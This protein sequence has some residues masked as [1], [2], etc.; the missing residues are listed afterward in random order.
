MGV[1]R[2]WEHD[3]VDEV[4]QSAGFEDVQLLDR[5]PRKH[6]TA[7]T[8]RAKQDVA[9]DYMQL[10]LN[11]GEVQLELQ[12][13]DTR[14]NRRLSCYPQRPSKV[15]RRVRRAD[16]Q[17]LEPDQPH[18]PRFSMPPWTPTS[19]RMTTLP[20]QLKRHSSEMTTERVWPR[21]AMPALP[22]SP[23]SILSHQKISD[24]S[25]MLGRGI[26]C[27]LF[28]PL[29]ECLRAKGKD[30]DPMALRLMITGHMKKHKHLFS[31]F[32]GRRRTHGRA[33]RNGPEG[34]R[35]IHP[36]HLPG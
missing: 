30:K 33:K 17:R 32:M 12:R 13:Q 23:E 5:R 9:K 26:A 34:F 7:W 6:L 28:L 15:S 18:N 11:A 10:D 16:G 22:K 21:Q 19:S 25:T 24:W 20:H 27:C 29:T 4:L 8:L 1:P 2:N 35:R 36:S 14:K 31:G 3:R